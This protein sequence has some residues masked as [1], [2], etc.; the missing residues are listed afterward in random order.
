VP[1]GG[2]PGLKNSLFQTPGALTEMN[3]LEVTPNPFSPDADGHEDRLFINY[4]FEDPNYMLR[5]RIFD[6]Y[7]RHVRSLAH[8]LHAGFEGSLTW[9]GRHDDG[10]TGRI[11]IY[12][13]HIEAFNSSTGDKKQFK[14]VAVLARQF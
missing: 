3:T 12:I 11:G 6:R 9:D 2:T 4:L 14:K 5:V 8:S 13:V 10:V 7:G 1:A